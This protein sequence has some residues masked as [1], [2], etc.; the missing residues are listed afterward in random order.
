M[1]SKVL[2][3]I[4]SLS[5]STS[6]NDANLAAAG[7]VIRQLLSATKNDTAC[8]GAIAAIVGKL[9]GPAQEAVVAAIEALAR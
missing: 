4:F 9:E 6:N 7:S 8:A 3:R 1:E 2:Q 5:S